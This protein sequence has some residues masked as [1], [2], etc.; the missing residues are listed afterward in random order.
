MALISSG[1]RGGYLDG[2]MAVGE[3]I[4]KAL[5]ICCQAINLHVVI[6]LHFRGH[7]LTSTVIYSLRANLGSLTRRLKWNSIMLCWFIVMVKSGLDGGP[8]EGIFGTSEK[9]RIF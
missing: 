8:K 1:G 7:P 4:R 6:F 9:K 3:G 5:L 2:W